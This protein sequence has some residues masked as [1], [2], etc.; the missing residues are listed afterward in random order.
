MPSL[1][2]VPIDTEWY[3]CLVQFSRILLDSANHITVSHDFGGRVEATVIH[4]P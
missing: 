2:A 1:C 3:D 4:T